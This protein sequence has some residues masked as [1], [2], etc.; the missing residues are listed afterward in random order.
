M[1]DAAEYKQK[2]KVFRKRDSYDE[3]GYRVMRKPFCGDD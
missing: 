2:T 3:W 1:M